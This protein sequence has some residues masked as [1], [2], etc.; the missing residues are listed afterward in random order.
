MSRMIVESRP[1]GP[2]AMNSY[3]VGCA[4]TGQ[5]AIVDSGG[6]SEAMLALAAQHELE[7]TKLLQTHAHID[8][9]A[10][11]VQMKALT[12][13]PIYL[14][15]ADA[16]L[17]STASQQGRMFGLRIED[18][19]PFDEELAEGDVVE[20]GALRL[21]V[22]FTPGHAPGHVCFYEPEEHV[23]FGGDLIF[24][25]SIGRVDLP[26]ADP[27][28]MM[29]SLR[30][31]MAELEDDVRI[32]PGHMGETTMGRERRSNPFLLQLG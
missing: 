9:I 10:G 23:L 31:V 18:P 2:F 19:P 11:L 13:A 3:L 30:R 21:R 32:L 1:V 12:G 27:H 14:H 20:L 26:L 4:E 17:Y 25:G 6:D 8:H 16:P 28:E 22:L 15:P 7:V 24:A 29:R 5:A